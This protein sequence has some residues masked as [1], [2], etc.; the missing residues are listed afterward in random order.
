VK[1]DAGRW[2]ELSLF[3]DKYIEIF[4]E[5]GFTSSLPVDQKRDEWLIV[6]L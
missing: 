2:R 5:V 1:S 4:D 3:S 6:Y